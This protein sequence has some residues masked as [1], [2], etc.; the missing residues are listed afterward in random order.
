MKFINDSKKHLEYAEE[1]YFEHFRFAFT[2]G[3]ILVLTGFA[4]ILHSIIP[5]IFTSTASLM[6]KKLSAKFASRNAKQPY[7]N[8]NNFDI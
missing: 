1:K 7:Y 2:N 8:E 3:L 4:L 6:V 5:S